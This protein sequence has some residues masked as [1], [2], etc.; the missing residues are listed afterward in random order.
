M[1]AAISRTRAVA[2][3]LG[4]LWPRA[5]SRV[6]CNTRV[7]GDGVPLKEPSSAIYLGLREVVNAVPAPSQSV[8]GDASLSLWAGRVPLPADPGTVSGEA[9][10]FQ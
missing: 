5:V 4:R 7:K 10:R 3:C 2:L 9:R 1:A 6:K 8:A